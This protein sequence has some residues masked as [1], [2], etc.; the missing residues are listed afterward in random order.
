MRRSESRWAST[1]A[2][3]DAE[4]RL[5][6]AWEGREERKARAAVGKE[7]SEE[8]RGVRVGWVEAG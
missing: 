5:A 6:R 3:S 1:A 2:A 7:E 8:R 4:E